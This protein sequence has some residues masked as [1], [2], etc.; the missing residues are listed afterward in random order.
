MIQNWSLN[1]HKEYSFTKTSNILKIL[2][3]KK[4]NFE[5]FKLLHSCG[6]SRPIQTFKLN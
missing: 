3:I 5:I 6:P 4:N 2:L 1:A